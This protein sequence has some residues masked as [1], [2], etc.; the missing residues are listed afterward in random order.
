MGNII[1]MR[2]KVK[3][4]TDFFSPVKNLKNLNLIKNGFSYSERNHI[5][6]YEKLKKKHKKVEKKFNNRQHSAC[7]KKFKFFALLP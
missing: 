6:I 4:I 2:F 5:E 3:F 7:Q 1:Y